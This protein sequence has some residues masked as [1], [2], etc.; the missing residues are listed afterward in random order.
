MGGLALGEEVRKALVEFKESG[1]FIWSYA[2]LLTE[3][4]FYISSVA[5][6]LYVSPV[7]DVEWNGLSSKAVFFK[8][9]LDK[10]DIEA[11][12]FRVGAYKSAVEPF[13]LDK[14]SEASREQTT[15]FVNSIYDQIVSEMA[16]DL[17]IESTKLHDIS[18][19]M[20]VQTPQQAIDFGLI[21]GMLYRDQF[22]QKIADK[23]EVE[24]TKDINFV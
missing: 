20:T 3:G 15:S 10:L 18:N 2:D 1:K 24:K 4:G 22:L 17:G 9:T 8:G 11:Q 19:Q 16:P 5:D 14:M 6:E 12:I 21:T 7:G 13:M 23:I